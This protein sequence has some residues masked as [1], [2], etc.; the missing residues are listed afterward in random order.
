MDNKIDYLFDKLLEMDGSDLHMVEGQVPK[1][2]AHGRL[3]P[4]EGEP[5]LT[6]ESIRAYLEEICEPRRWEKFLEHMDLDFAYDKDET[7]R[8]RSNYYFQIHGMAAVFRVIPTKIMTLKELNLIPVMETF[9]HLRSGLVLVTG[10][11]G[12]GKSTTLA[13]IINHIND[14][15][16]R[17]I[18]T[19]EEPIEFVHPNKKSVFTQREVGMD[20]HSFA[21]GLRTACRQDADVILVGE[22][23]D[24]ETI[25]IA[26]SAASMGSLVFGTLHTNSAIKTVNR[27]I[28]VFPNESQGMARTM[29]ANS[30]RGICAQLLLKTTDGKRVAANEVLLEAEG[31]ASSIREGNINSIQN[32]MQSGKDMGMQIMDDAIQNFLFAGRITG[33]EAYLKAEVKANFSEYAPSGEEI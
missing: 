29:L 33:E 16:H 20:A 28:D 32:I 18:L 13:A 17:S 11:T 22:M 26:L 5:T 24:Y 27:I 6:Y 12:S 19:I 8:F 31:L 4:I 30:L 7:Y 2:R 23:R 25:S 1:V 10:P 21:D 14:N 9:A 3:K 15:Y